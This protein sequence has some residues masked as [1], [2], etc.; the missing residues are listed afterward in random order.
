MV[1]YFIL[2]LLIPISTIG[3][4]QSY[5]MTN[6]VV[7]DCNGTLSDSNV[8]I[9]GEYG[10]NENFT[11]TICPNGADSIIMDFSD[12]CTEINL[13]I[14]RFFDGSDT[15]SPLLGIPYSG[16]ISLPQI[17]ATSG[18][19]T[20]H[21]ESDASVL[22]TGWDASW[23]TIINTPPNP[24]FDPI[25]AQSCNTTSITLT[26]DQNLICSSLNAS[27]INI[28]GPT[29]QVI[30]SI[31]PIGCVG[32][33]TNTIQIDFSPG[34]NQN[35]TY[36][37]QLDAD[38]IDDCGNIWNLSAFGNFDVNDCPI[39]A[40]IISNDD[41]DT[42]CVG[43][44]LDLSANAWDGDGSYN[45]TWNNGLASN[46]GPHNVC[47]AATTTY[48]V[49]VT[50]GTSAPAG[51]ATKTIYVI[52]PV[53]M[54]NDTTICQTTP[55][56]DLDASPNIGYWTGPCFGND[57][58]VGI[59][60]PFW[61][62]T[63][64]KTVT[65][66]YYGCQ[67]TMDITID[68][69]NFWTSNYLVCPGSA[70]FNFA[71]NNPGG[72]YSGT[73]ITDVNAG[74]FDPL[75]AG[76]GTHQIT[77]TNAPCEDR[78]RWITVGNAIM[79]PDD[80]ICSNSGLYSPAVNPHGGAWTYP[81]NPSAITNWYWCRFDPVIAGA[82]THQLLYTY[83]DCIDTFNI[84]VFD[85]EAGSNLLR[86]PSN[87]PFN[88]SGAN[89]AGGTWSGMGIIDPINGTFDPNA[90][91]G[92]DFNPW[93]YYT[94]NGCYDSLRIYVRNTEI[95]TNPLA[96]FCDYDSDFTL[97]Y[98]NSGRTPWSGTWSGIGI[99]NPTSNGIFSPSV[100]GEGIHTLYYEV[101][102]CIDS[103]EITVYANP[104]LQDTTV[105]LAQSVFEIP[106]SISGGTWNGTGIVNPTNGSF[107]ASIA[108]IG[109]HTIEYISPND[110]YYYLDIN[111]TAMPTLNMNGLPNTW[112]LA[113]TNFIINAIPLGGN[114]YGTTNDSIFN[115]LD[116]GSGIFNITYTMGTGE[117]MV[118][119]STSILIDDTLKISPYFN[120][121]T[122]CIDDYVKI[123]ANGQGG[124]ELNY[125]YAWSN[126]LGNS[127]E[128]IVQANSNTTYTISLNDGCSQE[129][130]TSLD[131]IIQEDFNIAFSTSQI[132]CFGENG[133]IDLSISPS[134][135]YQYLWNDLNA[136]TTDNISGKAGNTYKVIVTDETNCIKEEYIEIPS[137]E[138]LVADFSISPND[139]CLDLLNSTYYFIDQ[140]IGATKGKWNFGNGKTEFYNAGNN[141]YH[142]YKDTGVFIVKLDVENDGNCKDSKSL[143][144]CI[145]SKTLV[146]A[147]T[148]FSPNGDNIND[149]F[150]IKAIGTGFV[151][152][153]IYDRWGEE[154]FSSNDVNIGWDGSFK[155]FKAS[156]GV[157][158]WKAKFYS[159]ENRTEQ[160]E[161]GNFHLIK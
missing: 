120:D 104:N 27:N 100:A 11:F 93:I 60:H 110:C 121:T 37:I 96:S 101:N 31:T 136:S 19:L 126:G 12:F 134:G 29:S 43:E 42:I 75:I 80:T 98:A 13:D 158:T 135:T 146:V 149:V 6:A 73:G 159:F 51:I 30:S 41:N 161:K 125:S 117:C 113:D 25:S 63:G 84:T 138:K 76:L 157:Y 9:S 57:T 127:S 123:G 124:N 10:H 64:I 24:I 115:P 49:T 148:A 74:T 58:L 50:D 87:A 128:V 118:S 143:S 35:G 85:I 152:Y 70:A 38:F 39:S 155:S 56:F 67:S 32:N 40:E 111:V 89:P 132:Q 8:G 141:I 3:L 105:C 45:Y 1:K 55:V 109:T 106:S 108:G 18:C 140:T 78:L 90:N 112:C 66:N 153:S 16:N 26:I 79:P 122:I 160:L 69:M 92:A 15:L 86:C 145:T 7:S 107:L 133:T 103:T 130:T 28:Y 54:P 77:Y 33:S 22:C 68:P 144:V 147:P 97:D 14:I 65:F 71:T 139:K 154:I 142:S 21:F 119:T 95:Q 82:G 23:Q 116:I 83:G 5:S 150:Y 62:G 2:S 137:F 52:Q 151:E 36:Q 91:G 59:F 94:L 17:I 102:S 46:S 81:A 114:W 44:C 20:I 129:A 61:C 88:L 53:V 47:P 131:I 48:Q 72:T 156:T 34:T 99:T 4:S